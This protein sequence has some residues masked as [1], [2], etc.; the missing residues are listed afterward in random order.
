MQVSIC[1]AP[2]R[3]KLAANMLASPL[4][5]CNELSL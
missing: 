2:V 4:P 1:G 3:N 5:T